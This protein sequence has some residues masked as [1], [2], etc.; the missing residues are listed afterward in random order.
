MTTLKRDVGFDYNGYSIHSDGRQ[1]ERYPVF[2]LIGKLKAYPG[3][4]ETLAGYL[5]DGANLLREMEGCYL[6]VITYATDDADTI[7]ITE[8]WRSK[9]DHQAS[10]AHEGVRAVITSARPLIAE[11]P[12]GFEVVPVG[13]KGLPGG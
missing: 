13:G 7:W 12:D 4:R 11:P 9:E 2:G 1:R 10:L 8:M 6:Y 3:Q 5:L